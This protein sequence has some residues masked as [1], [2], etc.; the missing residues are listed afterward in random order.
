MLVEVNLSEYV[1]GCLAPD[2]D[3]FTHAQAHTRTP[4]CAHMFIRGYIFTHT[5][6]YA[7]SRCTHMYMCTY[8]RILT[9]THANS[10]M[11]PHERTHF[12]F[13]ANEEFC[14]EHLVSN[15]EEPECGP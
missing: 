2:P 3:S 14:Q 7:N 15:G 5:C 1:L 8:L 12:I 9:P 4:T 6:S 11:F 10:C 13:F